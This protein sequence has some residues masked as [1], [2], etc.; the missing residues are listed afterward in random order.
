MFTNLK[1]KVKLLAAL[2]LAFSLNANA[3]TI[4]TNNLLDLRN[5]SGTSQYNI[6]DDGK[7]AAVS[8][9]FNFDFYGVTYN[10]GTISTNGCFSFSTNYCNDYTPDPLPDTTHT[11][12]PF[13]TDL[14][15][16][17]DSRILSKSFEDYFVVGW[18][19]MREFNRASDNSFEMFLSANSAIEFRYGEL[20]IINHDVLIGIQGSSTQYSQYLF[21]DECNTG[22]TNSSNCIT[23]NWNASNSNTQIENKSLTYNSQCVINPLSSTE[24]SG[25]ASAYLTQQCGLNSLHDTSCL[26]YWRAYDDQQCDLDSQY[27]PSCPGYTTQE[28]VAYFIEDE[29]DYGYIDETDYGYIQLFNEETFS[30]TAE[31]EI[32]IEE[33]YEEPPFIFEEEFY[34]DEFFEPFDEEP[35]LLMAQEFD[36]EAD[37]YFT[38]EPIHETMER[39]I[40]MEELHEESMEEPSEVFETI[41]ELDEWFEEEM[42]EEIIEEPIEEIEEESEELINEEPGEDIFRE[43]KDGSKREGQLR[44]VS[45]TIRTAMQSVSGGNSGTSIHATGNTV[46][47][48]G[49]ASSPSASANLVSSIA[50]TQQV[51]TMS[52]NLG[53]T[54]S[55]V[56]TFSSGGNTSTEVSTSNTIAGNTISATDGSADNV[57]INTSAATEVVTQNIKQQQDSMEEEQN[58]SGEYADSSDLVDFM[59]YVAGFSDYRQVQMPPEPIWYE[60][61]DIYANN[62][63]QDN[64]VAFYGLASNSINKLTDIKNLQPTLNGGNYGMAQ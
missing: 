46:A 37:V 29:Y 63:I 25:Y 43:R 6:S 18:Y 21:H 20:D 54:Q 39:L 45:A 8:L 2:A 61:R 3:W 40:L 62:I 12:Y 4:G 47:S 34:V 58:E 52:S 14:I 59:G 33:M 51:L 42:A 32:F 13:W 26:G 48:G 27:S 38:N 44:V 16:D 60:S 19:D 57:S 1:T 56:S 36:L 50:S 17:N 23:T 49:I 15:R 35:E 55:S 5:L 31:P 11:I 53:S 64:I 24:C 28:S 10:S 9:G 30:F 7:S 22:T 41:E